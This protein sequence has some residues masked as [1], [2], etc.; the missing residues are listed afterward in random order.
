MSYQFR[1]HDYVELAEYW[2]L[3]DDIEDSGTDNNSDELL[4]KRINAYM[5]DT[6]GDKK[7]MVK[8]TKILRKFISVLY[9]QSKK[10][11]YQYPVWKGLLN[12]KDDETLIKFTSVLLKGM[13]T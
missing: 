10:I 11:D 1:G 6:L 4:K 13:W 3:I 5:F 9:K 2:E 7:R 8:V 12:V